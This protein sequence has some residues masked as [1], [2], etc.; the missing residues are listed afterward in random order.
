MTL[1][2]DWKCAY[3]HPNICTM[4]RHK[5]CHSSNYAMIGKSKEEQDVF[6]KEVASEAITV[7]VE[8][9]GNKVKHI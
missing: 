9:I 1:L 5:D 6:A 4:I 7:T 8:E 3:Y 2:K